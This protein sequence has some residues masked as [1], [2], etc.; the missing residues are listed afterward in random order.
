MSVP[1]CCVK[2][3]E[4]KRTVLKTIEDYRDCMTETT[5][6][7]AAKLLI[8]KMHYSD[9]WMISPVEIRNWVDARID[10]EYSAVRLARE[11]EEIE[12][13]LLSL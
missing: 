1:D 2:L 7:L 6:D 13:Y 8:A 11:T 10:Y 9:E 5:K 4:R 12:C 3:L